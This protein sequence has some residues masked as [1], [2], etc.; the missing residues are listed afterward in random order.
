MLVLSPLSHV[1]GL[2]A[3]MLLPLHLG[4]CVTYVQSTD[5]I[6]L[7][8]VIRDNRISILLTVP[9]LLKLLGDALLRTRVAAKGTTLAS[10]IQKK[11][12]WLRPF[13]LLWYKRRIAG[14]RLRLIMV[15]GARL[16]LETERF[17]RRAGVPVMQGYGLT[18]TTATVTYSNPFSLQPGTIGQPSPLH[19][20][21]LDCRGEILVRGPSL[22]STGGEGITGN[23]FYRTGDL[24]RWD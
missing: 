19:E 23:G 8:R 17:W 10:H 18:E 21:R 2:V 3:G 7:L 16:P 5:P 4:L 22:A 11:P 24:G 14:R 13:I 9:R 1:Q 20:V 15:G 6:Y 12:Q